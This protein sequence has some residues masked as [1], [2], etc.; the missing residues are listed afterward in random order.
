[1]PLNEELALV[2]TDAPA[3]ELARARTSYEGP[4]NF[5]NGVRGLFSVLAFAA[6]IGACL[7][8]GEYKAR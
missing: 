6:L 7:L 5:W 1:V 8:G 2:A 3:D 4:W